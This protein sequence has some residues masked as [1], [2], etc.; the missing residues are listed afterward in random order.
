MTAMTDGVHHAPPSPRSGQQE[1]P[2]RGR[3]RI[4][5][6]FG[7]MRGVR[8]ACTALSIAAVLVL[9]PAY[10]LLPH[11]A[12]WPGQQFEIGRDNDI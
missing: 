10:L 5:R 4:L 7:A 8:K 11:T 2:R 3:R 1:K 12:T 6:S 9:L